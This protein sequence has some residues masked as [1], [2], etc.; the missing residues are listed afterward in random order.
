MYYL[1]E[2]IDGVIARLDK[3]PIEEETELKRYIDTVIE[4][5]GRVLTNICFE[6]MVQSSLIRNDLVLECEGTYKMVVHIPLYAEEIVVGM[7]CTVIEEDIS[8]RGDAGNMEAYKE[9][10]KLQKI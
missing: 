10:L 8:D 1:M 5:E 4:G 3:L 9:L 2:V 7:P 6:D